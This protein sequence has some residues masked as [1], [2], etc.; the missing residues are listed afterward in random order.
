[1][2]AN[3]RRDLSHMPGLHELVE[4]SAQY[5]AA[6]RAALDAGWKTRGRRRVLVRAVIGHAVEFETWRSLARQQGL[7]DREA[8]EIMV[9][10]V[11]ATRGC[12]QR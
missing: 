4:R 6:V 9:C 2:S 1:M 8:A 5:W 3:V 12:R 10:L 11:A 7:D